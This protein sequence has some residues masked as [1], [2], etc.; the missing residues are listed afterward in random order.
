MTYSNCLAVFR[1]IV[2]LAEMAKDNKID[3][4]RIP[5]V[6][7]LVPAY[8][9]ESAIEATIKSLASQTIPLKQ[10]IVIANNCKDRTAE[11][12]R[13]LTFKYSNL[14]VLEMKENN[15]KK[16]GALNYGFSHI[17]PTNIDYIFQM[18]A[19]TVLEPDC[20]EEGLKELEANPRLGGTCAR[21]GP[22][23][24]PEN[25]SLW[26]RFLW[27]MQSLEYGLS[28]AYRVEIGTARVL[29]GAA[30]MYRMEALQDV[31]RSR[32]GES[33]WNERSI[34]EDY[35]LTLD[36]KDA[37]WK[38][39]TCME[40]VCWT[41]VPL[42]LKDLRI[43]RER[44]GSGTIDAIREKGWRK[45]TRGEILA[46]IYNCCMFLIQLLAL[47]LASWAITQGYYFVYSPLLILFCLPLIWN[48]Y[49]QLYR[50]KYVLRPDATQQVIIATVV[51]MQLYWLFYRII[52]LNSLRLS[53]TNAN[54]GWGQPKR[55][56]A[57]A[58]TK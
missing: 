12:A 5:K 15:G 13:N 27:R 3:T 32:G 44:W 31:L 23:D 22:N 1:A 54:R 19:D 7:A 43:Q 47:G 29:S 34:I 39:S 57:I 36:V 14:T 33:V 25:S 49:E 4:P 9:E 58:K 40:M 41:A 8:N 2:Y 20:I 35:Y 28:D 52:F 51:V 16:A 18:D 46:T 6:V 38:T 48:W 26:Q 53:Y 21:Y 17:D 42:N 50:Y 45:S 56:V 55:E 11:I 30:S 10:I 24:L 37:G